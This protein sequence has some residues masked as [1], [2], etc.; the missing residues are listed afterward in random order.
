M[1]TEFSKE[2]ELILKNK[3]IKYR[4]DGTSCKTFAS[5]IGSMGFKSRADQI[6]P[7]LPSTRHRCKGPSAKPR[8]WAP[9]TRDTRKGIKRV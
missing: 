7:T 3:L 1:S 6:S 4:P 8:R 9:L 2:F 5:D